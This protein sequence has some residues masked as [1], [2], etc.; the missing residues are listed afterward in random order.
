MRLVLG[1]R[2]SQLALWQAG[3]V[4]AA[5]E[6]LGC[7]VEIQVIKTS[8]DRYQR[9]ALSEIGNKGLFVKE[10]EEA[11]LAREID[12]AVHSLKDMPV[13]LPEGLTIAAFPP[14]EEPRDALV[15]GRLLE[16]PEGARVGTGSLRR[17]A[18]LLA[19]RTDLK[20]TALRGNVDT[21]LRRLDAGEF[22]AVVLAA[23]GLQRL[24]L[25]DRIAQL[26]PEQ[27]MCP[28]PGQGALAVE[29]RR[30]GEPL[31]VCSRLDDPETRAAVIAE[32]EVMRELEA[33]C[34]TPVGALGR[35]VGSHLQLCAAVASADGSQVVRE[36][37]CAPVEE[38]VE[39][40]RA[41]ARRLLERGAGELL[42]RP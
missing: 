33:G 19:A 29:T 16:L 35:V 39:A 36:Q 34:Q 18:Q 24:G 4:R 21:R 8:G 9:G 27:I 23:A 40:G 38:A 3:W 22:E 5:L 6:K 42:Q 14:R 12:V 41:L 17:Q 20:V 31:E 26:L 7:E 25:A 10:I 15:G 28:A 11:L 37:L 2:G 30:E 13:R 1:S 32:R